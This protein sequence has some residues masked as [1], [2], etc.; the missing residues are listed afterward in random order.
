M[1]GD[2]CHFLITCTGTWAIACATAWLRQKLAYRGKNDVLASVRRDVGG[3]GQAHS[4]AAT[5]P[6]SSLAAKT[7]AAVPQCVFARRR[8][9]FLPDSSPSPGG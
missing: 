4:R 8:A 1:A 3:R 2:I 5:S 7:L 9:A 6:A